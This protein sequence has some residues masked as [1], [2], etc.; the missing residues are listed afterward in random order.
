MMIYLSTLLENKT[1]LEDFMF[2]VAPFLSLK[3]TFL[4]KSGTCVFFPSV[5]PCQISDIEAELCL[6]WICILLFVL[7]YI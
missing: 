7:S 3:C 6:A 2:P 4:Q 5:A 1:V